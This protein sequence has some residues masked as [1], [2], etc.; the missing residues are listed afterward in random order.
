MP[1]GEVWLV[2]GCHSLLGSAFGVLE[3]RWCQPAPRALPRSC[4][5][6]ALPPP[7]THQ[8]SGTS[9]LPSPSCIQMSLPSQSRS[10]VASLRIRTCLGF[11]GA[12]LQPGPHEH[13]HRGPGQRGPGQ[14]GRLTR[15]G[16]WSSRDRSGG[17]LCAGQQGSLRGPS[18]RVLLRVVL[19]G[20]PAPAGPMSA[21]GTGPHSAPLGVWCGPRAS[22]G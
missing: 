20:A 7:S 2:W 14:G 6:V 17:R 15:K 13:L 4:P 11:S 9:A 1:L 16:P 8:C 18:A 19:G 10:G 22:G 12:S 3:A 21:G 5:R